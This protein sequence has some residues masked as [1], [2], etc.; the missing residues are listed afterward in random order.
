MAK[1]N[2][3]QTNRES[4]VSLTSKQNLPPTSR[5]IEF[6]P[7]YSYVIKDLRMIGILAGS[8]FTFLVILAFIIG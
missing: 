4:P 8:I 2:K 1:K 3:R 6:Q 7:D 5:Q